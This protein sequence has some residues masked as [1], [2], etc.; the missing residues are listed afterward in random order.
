[1]LVPL[2]S[3]PSCS[4]PVALLHHTILT[5]TLCLSRSPPHQHT[6]T[7]T[8]T[9]TY[10]HSH[11][12]QHPS[13]APFHLSSCQV[14]GHTAPFTFSALDTT[15]YARPSRPEQ[16]TNVCLSFDLQSHPPCPPLVLLNMLR[17]TV[18]RVSLMP[19]PIKRLSA[20]SF[21]L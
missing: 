7:H 6:H 20:A 10:T 17:Q 12:H 3:L 19:S 11:T 15:H 2:V 1:M 16:S 13:Q 14:S 8:H 4:L 21:D 5:H 18:R 9:H